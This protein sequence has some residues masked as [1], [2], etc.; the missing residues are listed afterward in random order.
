MYCLKRVNIYVCVYTHM[1]AHTLIYAQKILERY[2]KNVKNTSKCGIGNQEV[3]ARD[4][5]FL[6][7]I[8]CPSVLLDF[9]TSYL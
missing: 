8:L 6:L 4:L 3:K 5:L 1:H 2:T 7:F 9:A